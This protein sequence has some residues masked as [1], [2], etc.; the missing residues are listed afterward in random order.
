M[1]DRIA[2]VASCEEH[3]QAWSFPA[4]LLRQLPPIH[5]WQHHVRKKQANLGV[6]IL[7]TKSV[8]SIASLNHAVPEVEEHLYRQLAHLVI[9]LDDK[10]HLGGRAK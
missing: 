8:N 7:C 3:L 4:R 9:V 2:R 1:D 5:P 6:Q 10:N